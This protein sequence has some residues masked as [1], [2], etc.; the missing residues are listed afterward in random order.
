MRCG[1]RGS[2]WYARAACGPHIPP[3]QPYLALGQDASAMVWPG[4]KPVRTYPVKAEYSSVLA[5]DAWLYGIGPRRGGSAHS[6]IQ[7]K[8]SSPSHTRRM[9]GLPEERR[10]RALPRSASGSAG[11]STRGGRVPCEAVAARPA[12]TPRAGK[13][14][15]AQAFKLERTLSP[16]HENG[17]L[18]T[19]PAS[20]SLK[21]SFSI[22]EKVGVLWVPGNLPVRQW[23]QPTG[24]RAHQPDSH[25]RRMSPEPVMVWG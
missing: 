15:K 14:K 13:G 9:R 22:L 25:G 23:R 5:H 10:N 11:R 2:C 19:P 16:R 17:G 12:R 1:F 20:S 18:D 3:G 7:G 6:V 8:T 24:S 21:L 4:D